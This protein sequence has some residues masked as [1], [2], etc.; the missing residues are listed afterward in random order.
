MSNRFSANS[1]KTYFR[2]K[3]KA[4]AA[5][6]AA[7]QPQQSPPQPQ[8]SQPQS[9]R[10]PAELCVKLPPAQS[11]PISS[12]NRSAANRF[13]A[14]RSSN[15]GLG[16]SGISAARPETPRA[17]AMPSR[18]HVMTDRSRCRHAARRKISSLTLR[19]TDPSHSSKFFPPAQASPGLRAA[20]KKEGT[21]RCVAGVSSHPL[22]RSSSAGTRVHLFRQ[23]AQRPAEPGGSAAHRNKRSQEDTRL[24]ALAQEYAA[25]HRV[26]MPRSCSALSLQRPDPQCAFPKHDFHE[27]ADCENRLLEYRGGEIDSENRLGATRTVTTPKTHTRPFGPVRKRLREPRA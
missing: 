15:A 1:S 8:Q 4:V 16:W 25:F 23:R 12:S 9:Q 13:R 27:T 6:S 19:C 3:Q 17:C 2:A 11:Q 22:G 20:R 10:S 18:D 7:P 5:K 14:G 24:L 26:C 21:S